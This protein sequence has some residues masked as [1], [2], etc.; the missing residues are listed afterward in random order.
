MSETSIAVRLQPLLERLRQGDPQAGK[1][2]INITY[3]RFQ[4]LARKVLRSGFARVKRWEETDD[5]VQE[6]A[7]RL[8]KSL[9][10][11]KPNSVKDYLNL[12]SVHIRRELLDLCRRYF[13]RKAGGGAPAGSPVHAAGELAGD[14]IHGRD[15]AVGTA[16]EF[17]ELVEKL[18]E[19]EREVVGLLYY[20]GLTQEEAAEVLEVDRSTV[21]RRWRSARLKLGEALSKED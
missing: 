17:H 20:Q 3:E 18:P 10:T 5:V 9:E 13:G 2:M 6:A 7:L 19:D 14:D 15:E 1:E 16:V 4:N 21:K 12:G 11:V 8:W